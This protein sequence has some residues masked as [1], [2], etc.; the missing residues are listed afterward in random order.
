MPV[1]ARLLLCQQGGRNQRAD[2]QQLSQACFYEQSLA[3][4]GKK[5]M[6]EAKGRA[7]SLPHSETTYYFQRALT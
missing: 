5:R 1:T 2:C 7:W 3:V 4:S 6:V